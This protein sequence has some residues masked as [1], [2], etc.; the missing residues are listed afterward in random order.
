MLSVLAKP[1]IRSKIEFL[2]TIM[3]SRLCQFRKHV[4]LLLNSKACICYFQS[5]LFFKVISS[6][7]SPRLQEFDSLLS[8]TLSLVLNVDLSRESAW[9]QTTLPVSGGGIGARSAS[10]HAS[11][12]HLASAAGC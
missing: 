9:L 3:G 11:S 4:A 12:A 10:M 8:S 7:L 2:K 6:L 1:C 5:S